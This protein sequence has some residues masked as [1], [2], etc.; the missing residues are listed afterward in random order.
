MKKLLLLLIIPFLS[1]GQGDLQKIK[2]VLYKQESEWNQGNLY[3]FMLGYW[4]SDKLEFSSEDVTTY[5]WV[6]TFI[7]YKKNYPTKEKMGKLQFEIIDTKLTSDTTA[8][9]KGK[10]ELL[11]THDKLWSGWFVLTFQKFNDNW[12]IIK[13]YT[14]SE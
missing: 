13:D 12:L 3:G 6:N 10:W 7:K 4:N 8:L 11:R 1:F 2:E 5:G 14:T 9:V